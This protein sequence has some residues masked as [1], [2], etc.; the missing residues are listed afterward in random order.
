MPI[1]GRKVY[2]KIRPRRTQCLECDNEPTTTERYPWRVPEK[3]RHKDFMA[4]YAFEALCED[5]FR[6]AD[7]LFQCG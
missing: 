3:S 2:L 7:F 6:I 4:L 5:K 1:L